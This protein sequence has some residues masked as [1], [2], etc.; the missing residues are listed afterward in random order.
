MEADQKVIAA[1]GCYAMTATTALTAQ[2]TLGVHEIHQVPTQFLLKQ[3][4]ACFDDTGVDVV[5]TGQFT[6][7]PTMHDMLKRVMR[8]PGMLA[9]GATI[10]AVAKA[11]KERQVKQLVVDPVM[12]ATT[13]A[14]L[15]PREAVSELR[16][17]LL[18]LATV[19]TPNIPEARIL[20]SNAGVS[21]TAID[22]VADLE[23]VAKAVHGLGSEWVLV[24]GGHLPFRD[25][26]MAAQSPAERRLVVD[27]LVGHG[28]TLTIETP[29]LDSRNTHGTG[30]SL[31]CK[32]PWAPD[33]AAAADAADTSCYC[34]KFGQGHG[35]S[36][37][38]PGSVQVCGGSHQ[39]SARVGQWEWAA[40]P[41]SLD[42]HAAFC[43]V[44]RQLIARLCLGMES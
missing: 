27:V 12:V 34:I 44:S 43:A 19:L 20:L 38:R 42:L 36:G 41:L 17:H 40:E 2:N 11:L 39:D 26:Y 25:D 3:I 22:S 8:V 31:A 35:R 14:P 10:E 24:K 32:W 30:C 37:G 33:S 13:G 29:Y 18:P 21:P 16:T 4:D 23:A 1:H 6:C 15:L 28:Q 5:K 7:T 9:S